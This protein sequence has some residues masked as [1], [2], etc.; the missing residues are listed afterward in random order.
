M[1]VEE[2]VV[3]AGNE[4]SLSNMVLGFYEEA[5]LQ[6]SPPGDCA[7]AAGDDD[8]GSDD[9]GSGGAAKCRAFWK[10]QQSQL[11][12]ALAKMSSA[13]SRIQ[14]DAE[15]AMRQMRAA[16]G[17]ACSCASRG[18]AAAAAGGG[19][20][21]SCTLRFLAER[22]RDAGYNSAICRSKWP[23]SPE[24]PSG[25]HSYVDVVAPTRSG[26]AVRV[27][28]EPS[29]R[30]E[31]EMARGGAGYRALVA[32]LPEAFVGRADRLRGVV[33][34]MCAAA[35][36]CARE[37]GMHMAPWRKQRYMEA[38]WLATP[39]RVAPP[40]NAGGAGDAVAVGSPS[41]PLSPGMTNRQMQPKFRASMLT[42][43]FG[44]RTAVEVV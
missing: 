13:E 5:E 30:G 3:A 8:D 22:L 36:Q 42:L 7:A 6:S 26:K 29:F 24:I 33:R 17:G 12:E 15:E 41:S 27:V 43:D 28:V 31:F 2:A 19:G 44:G 10:E 34:V 38:K 25:E 16:A 37:S 32:S 11:Y 40:G 23:R 4:M 14:A 39:E 35:K 20:C 1:V 21:R 9:E 18:A